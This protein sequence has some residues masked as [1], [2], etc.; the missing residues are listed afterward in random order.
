MAPLGLCPS[1][2]RHV[3]IS[4]DVCPFCDHAFDA[5]LDP[6][7]SSAQRRTRRLAAAAFTAGIALAGC[8]GG[9]P[10][11]EYGAPPADGGDG[12]TQPLY[13]AVMVDGGIDDA[14]AGNP[15]P[16]Y[17]APPADGGFE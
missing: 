7:V 16:E 11:P 12:S 4:E 14:D 15:Q 1:C 10:Q 6:H 8:D 3:Q 9:N 17:G 5:A 13:G 2:Q